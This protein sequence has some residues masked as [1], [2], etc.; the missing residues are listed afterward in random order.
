MRQ[1]NDYNSQ[2]GKGNKH[3]FSAITGNEPGHT[4][5]PVTPIS[6]EHS[7]IKGLG[8]ILNHFQGSHWPRTISTKATQGKQV[9]VYSRQEALTYFKAAGYLDCRIN[10]YP[11]WRSSV[12]SDFASI[13][14]TIVPYTI[15][16][17]LDI[18]NFNYEHIALKAALRKIL[19][20]IRGLLNLNAPTVIWSGNGYHIYISI[21]IPILLE[22]IKEFAGT[23]HA[24]TKFLRF[25]EWYLSSGMSDSAHNSTV[26]LNNCM[27][28]IPFSYNSKNNAQ[29]RIIKKWDGNRPNISLLI[30]SF[31]T[32]LTDKRL[33]DEER[34][35]LQKHIYR[36]VIDLNNKGSIHWIERLLITPIND[37]RKYAIW[38][39]LAP[40]IINV[41]CLPNDMAYDI[42]VKWLDQCD[43]L[44]RLDF[45][46]DAKIKEGLTSA[47]RGYLPVSYRKLKDENIM[48]YGILHT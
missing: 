5:T 45:H 39:I 1:K 13:K 20:R 32:Y 19:N 41:K 16:I 22:D 10:A 38:R 27:L 2:D 40:Y 21:N 8:Y 47:S 31:C 48:L 42:I 44:R 9:I 25:A 4:V 36:N 18:H 24:S 12:I 11:Y 23:E 15:M 3:M 7:C 43:K 33:K 14:N 6:L 26:S 28:R 29:V 46:P 30:G 35:Q 34:K 17:D 37:C